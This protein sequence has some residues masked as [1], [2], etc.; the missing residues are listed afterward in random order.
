MEDMNVAEQEKCAHPQC[1]CPVSEGQ[2][3]AARLARMPTSGNNPGPSAAATISNVHEL[4]EP[5]ENADQG[6]HAVPWSAIT[7][8]KHN[9][10]G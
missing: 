10:W 3:T 5:C 8:C 9:L 6:L 1:T 4:H 7:S 2:R